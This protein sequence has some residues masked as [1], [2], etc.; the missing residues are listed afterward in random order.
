MDGPKQRP[1]L[2]LLDTLTA[3]PEARGLWYNEKDVFL[4]GYNFVS[5]RFDKCKLYVSSEHF[6]MRNC[7]VDDETVIYYDGDIVKVLRL[8]NSRYPWVYQEL[9]YFAPVKNDDGT[10]SIT[11][12]PQ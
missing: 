8:F 7:F 1:D 2:N 3:R 4:D 11:T 6:E 10:I 9:P 5:C 12:D